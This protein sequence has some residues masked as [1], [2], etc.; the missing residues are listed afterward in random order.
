M[1]PS[2]D[3]ELEPSVSLS[4]GGGGRPLGDPPSRRG[5]K[6]KS[7]SKEGARSVLMEIDSPQDHSG[8]N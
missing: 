4:D 6:E 5:E 7:P 3:E 1:N 8:S 2:N